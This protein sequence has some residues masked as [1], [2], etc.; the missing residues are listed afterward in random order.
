MDKEPNSFYVNHIESGEWLQ[1]TISSKEDGRYD[2][3]LNL[4]SDN[5]S[6]KIALT[7]NAKEIK[8]EVVVPDT[9]G[10]WQNIAA[11]SI[12]LKKGSNVIRIKALNGGFNFK[13]IDLKKS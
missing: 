8:D 6:G 4:S 1:Y 3:F 7:V 13:S 2:L 11:E 5:A 9:N 12:K 10:Q